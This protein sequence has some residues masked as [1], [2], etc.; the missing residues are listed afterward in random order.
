MACQRLP[1]DGWP[2]R[3][4]VPGNM[5]LSSKHPLHRRALTHWALILVLLLGQSYA[6]AHD[7]DAHQGDE[8]PCALCVYAQ[9]SDTF[10]QSAAYSQLLQTSHTGSACSARQQPA[11]ANLLPF[12]SRAPPVNAC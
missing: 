2:Q 5:M 10:I 11:A 8:A 3:N 7:H 1:V 4:Y 12:H 9:Q 6:L